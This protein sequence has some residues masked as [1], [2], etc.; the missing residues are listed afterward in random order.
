MT[1][2]AHKSAIAAIVKHQTQE[3]VLLHRSTPQAW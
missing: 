3:R 1:I 2:G